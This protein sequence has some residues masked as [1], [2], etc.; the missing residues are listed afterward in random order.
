MVLPYVYKLIHKITGQFYIG[1]RKANKIYSNQDIGVFYFSSSAVVNKL[2]FENFNIDIIAEFFKPEDAYEFEQNLIK[3]NFKDQLILN[4][5]H[6]ADS[7]A[8][9]N[10][11]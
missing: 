9:Y 3:E 11:F 6:H 2:G 8:N 5:R 4:K 10:M 7:N 1:F